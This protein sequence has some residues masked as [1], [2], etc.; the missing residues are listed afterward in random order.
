MSRSLSFAIAWKLILAFA[1]SASSGLL[2]LPLL[3][4]GR[5]DEIA[6]DWS[7][8]GLGW[9]RDSVEAAPE[10]E[11]PDLV[12]R[13]GSSFAFPLWIE[14]GRT[15]RARLGREPTQA[16]LLGSPSA[17]VVLLPFRGGGALLAGPLPTPPPR[18]PH[19]LLPFYVAL[20]VGIAAAL[21]IAL[22]LTRR[23]RRL[24]QGTRALARGELGARVEEPVQ[25]VIGELA[26]SFNAM[27]ER[28]QALFGERE[29]LLQAVS[30]ELATPLARIRFHLEALEEAREDELR[31]K[32]LLAVDKELREIDRLAIEL[33]SWV[34][35]NGRRPEKNALDLGALLRELVEH[36]AAGI[37]TLRAELPPEPLLVRGD[38]VQLQ[39]ALGNVVRNAM[40]HAA[41]TVVVAARPEGER[42][43][44]EIRDD[45][46]GVPVEHRRRVLEPFAR[47]EPSR[48]RAHGGMGLGLAIAHRIA[49]AHDGELWIEAAPEGGAAVVLRLPQETT[50]SRPT[51]A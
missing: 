6:A 26:Q 22:P 46:P 15:I 27:A 10:A 20:T 45:G 16:T 51:S 28:L 40:R 11:R 14:D 13:I 42:V 3:D 4:A 41:R 49:L 5:A 33:S 24:Q 2:V 9:A 29:Q 48:S 44:V 36:E 35:A 18:G 12:E 38:A 21:L 37:R 43:R 30:H 47:L 8:L 17:S 19:L 34:E 1:I 7:R 23:L 31:K 32:R 25:D 39:R 50:G